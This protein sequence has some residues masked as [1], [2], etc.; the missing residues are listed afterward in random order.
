MALPRV[1]RAD[2]QTRGFPVPTVFYRVME[3]TEDVKAWFA[4]HGRWT[5][6]RVGRNEDWVVFDNPNL[7]FAFKMRFL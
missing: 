6:V 7:A 5:E 3:Q 1:K 2:A 4:E